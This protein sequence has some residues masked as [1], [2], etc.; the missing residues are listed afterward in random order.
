MHC[1]YRAN[2][3]LFQLRKGR[4]MAKIGGVRHLVTVQCLFV[5]PDDTGLLVVLDIDLT[6]GG[7]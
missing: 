1:D 4:K 7:L 5:C 6:L 2:K 3:T